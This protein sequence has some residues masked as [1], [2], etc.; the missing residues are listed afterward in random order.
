MDNKNRK[1][2]NVN[3][4]VIIPCYNTPKD[5]LEAAVNSAQ[6]A[7]SDIEIVLEQLLKRYLKII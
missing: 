2:G 7:D 5:F 4:S 1:E 6:Q 3:L